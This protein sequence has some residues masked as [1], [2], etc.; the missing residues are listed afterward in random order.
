MDTIAEL[1]TAMSSKEPREEAGGEPDVEVY[2]SHHIVQVQI[3]RC[4]FL[5][6]RMKRNF[7]SSFVSGCSRNKT[8]S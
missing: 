8:P 4:F 5:W 3:G 7:A 2:G 1:L 6:I